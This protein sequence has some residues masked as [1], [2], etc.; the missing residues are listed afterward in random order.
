MAW[1]YAVDFDC[2]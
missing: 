2:S 1:N